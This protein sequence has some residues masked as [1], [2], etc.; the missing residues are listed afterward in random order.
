MATYVELFDL[1]TEATL[2]KRISY[3]KVVLAAQIFA[4]NPATPNH[5]NRLIFAQRILVDGLQKATPRV[6]AI[7]V[8]ADA[9]VAAAGA[10]CTDAQILTALTNIL[11]FLVG[12]EVG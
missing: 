8:L 2:A 12:L 7:G 10:T 6:C 11:D 1:I 3:A 5:A 9:A 4:E